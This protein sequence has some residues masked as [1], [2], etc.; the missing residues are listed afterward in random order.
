[1]SLILF[2]FAGTLAHAEEALRLYPGFVTRVRCE[3]R[4]LLS[5]VG[6]DRLIRLDA[7]PR[8]LGCGV[9][10]KPT[11]SSGRTNL[12]LETSTGTVQRILV[13]TGTG[14]GPSSSDL[15]VQLKGVQQ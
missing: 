15:E 1:M 9:I 10:L 14:T 6:D 11:N 8:E 7:L 13:V 4:L 3:G 5:S 12:I 2:L